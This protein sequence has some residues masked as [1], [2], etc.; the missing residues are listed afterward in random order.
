MK[1][2]KIFILLLLVGLVM[3][4]PHAKV[5]D[6]GFDSS[7]GGGGYSSSDSSWSSSDSYSSHSSYDYG[8]SYGGSSTSSF[9]VAIIEL[10]FILVIVLL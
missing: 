3:V 6:S 2:T 5:A 7:Y 10:I 1:K 4:S 9:A 8:S